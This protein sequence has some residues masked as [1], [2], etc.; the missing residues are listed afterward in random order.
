MNA[1]MD[2]VRRRQAMMDALQAYNKAL[3]DASDA[4]TAEADTP[5]FRYTKQAFARQTLQEGGVNV[6]LIAWNTLSGGA[7]GKPSWQEVYRV[8]L[9]ARNDRAFFDHL[10][11]LSPVLRAQF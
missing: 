4:R 5:H 8:W 6:D 9:K 10:D 1:I 7:G 2:K 3:A 11:I